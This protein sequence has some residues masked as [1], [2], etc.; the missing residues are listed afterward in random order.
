MLWGR[1]FRSVKRTTWLLGLVLSFWISIAPGSASAD[2]YLPVTEMVFHTPFSPTRLPDNEA[3]PVSLALVETIRDRDGSYPPALREL[4]L[5]LDR[6]LGL[7]VAGVPSCPRPLG[8]RQSRQNPFEKCEEAKVGS[9]V[10][11]LEVGFP[12]QIPMSMSGQLHIYNGGFREGRTM[13]WLFV[14]FPAPITGGILMPLEVRRADDG[15]Y[16]WI[17]E[18]E[19]PRIA[20]GHASITHLGARFRKG[21]FSASCPRGSLQTR[22]DARFAEGS[23][24]QGASIHTC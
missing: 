11:E 15:R 3:R 8:G 19:I 16:G 18:L 17:G 1:E 7:S 23:R 2:V 21:I 24:V 9:G 6:H 4:Q 10:V 13:F 20:D 5:G 22:A 14:Y 12:E